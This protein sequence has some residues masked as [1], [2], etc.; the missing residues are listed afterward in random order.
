MIEFPNCNDLNIP[1]E[2]VLYRIEYADHFEI[3][4][5][6]YAVQRRYSRIFPDWEV[7]FL[8]IHAGNKKECKAQ[9]E[10]VIETLKRMY[11]DESIII[12]ER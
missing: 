4:E 11:L 10:R 5:M 12:S 2:D 6:I 9:V 3:N 8:S 1:L 7:W